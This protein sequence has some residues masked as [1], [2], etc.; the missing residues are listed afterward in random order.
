[1]LYSF[2]DT[3]IIFKINSGSLSGNNVYVL[4]NHKEEEVD[5]IYSVMS[6]KNNW[7]VQQNRS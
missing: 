7:I 4:E 1:M 5:M 6:Y 3:M 2:N